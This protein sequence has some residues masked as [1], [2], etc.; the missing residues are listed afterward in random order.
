VDPR[1]PFARSED[2]VK[3]LYRLPLAGTE[4]SVLTILPNAADAAAATALHDLE[5][6]LGIQEALLRA[7]GFDA[8]LLP[9]TLTRSHVLPASLTARQLAKLAF[10]RLNPGGLLIGHLDH[11]VAPRHLARWAST[12]MAWRQ[13]LAWR[14]FWSTTLCR[15]SLSQVGFEGIECYFVE[16]H[17]HDPM[18]L[19]SSV[20]AAAQ[21][22]FERTIR[23]NRPLYSGAGYWARIALAKAGWAGLLQPHLF[24][25][26]RRPC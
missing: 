3:L 1:L 14:G 9:G 16:P 7:D 5:C 11:V 8:V 20:P 26:A 17:M 13:A 10:E 18:A 19:V 2:R 21:M 22:H 6:R 4:R 23:R 15:R 24:F 25:W 12:G